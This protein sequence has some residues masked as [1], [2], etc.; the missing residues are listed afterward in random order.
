[1]VLSRI[2]KYIPMWVELKSRRIDPQLLIEISTD[3][4]NL[5]HQALYRICCTFQVSE[6][7]LNCLPGTEAVQESCTMAIMHRVYRM[8]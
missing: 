4:P 6:V 7:F 8:E 5:A 1:M 2:D 3:D